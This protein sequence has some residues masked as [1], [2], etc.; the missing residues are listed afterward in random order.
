MVG[1]QQGFLVGPDAGDRVMD[2]PDWVRVKLYGEDSGGRFGIIEQQL[3][4]GS[5]VPPHVHERNDVCLFA[6][7]GEVG[8]RVGDEIRAATPGTLAIKPMGVPHTI[9]NAGK[10]PARFIELF[11]PAGFERFFEELGALLRSPD[12]SV[13]AAGVIGQK[14]GWRLHP[15]WTDELKARFGLHVIG[16]E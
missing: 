10:V 1:G 7:E 3:A 2:G 11:T 5:L 16:E 9:W 12:F 8:V 14:Y 4:P 6:L 13:E 15:E